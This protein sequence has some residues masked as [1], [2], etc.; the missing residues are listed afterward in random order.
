[1]RAQVPEP[2]RRS[3]SAISSPRC[4]PHRRLH[5]DHRATTVP[6]PTTMA[7]SIVG[8]SSQLGPE[9]AISRKAKATP[10]E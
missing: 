9:M 6:I 10:I 2:R 3:D 8:R 1:M 5:D 4:R 7:G